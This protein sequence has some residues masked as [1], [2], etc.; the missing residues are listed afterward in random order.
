M[1][2]TRTN[3]HWQSQIDDSRIPYRWQRFPVNFLEIS[4]KDAE[5]RGIES[6]DWVIVENDSVIN[7]IGGRSSGMFKAVAYVTAQVPPGV[8]CSYFLFR[9]GRLDMAA[10]NVTPGNTDPINNRYRYKLGKG[11]VRKTGESEFKHTMSFVPR[12]LV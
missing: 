2:N 3:E 11:R 1:T 8:T 5:E 7:Q 9:Q 6:G 12:N 10:N 4:P